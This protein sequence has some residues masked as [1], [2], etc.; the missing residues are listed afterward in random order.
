MCNP[1]SRLGSPSFVRLRRQLGRDGGVVNSRM[2]SVVE[3]FHKMGLFTHEVLVS[4][5][6][7]PWLER[8]VVFTISPWA[9][10]RGSALIGW[11]RVDTLVGHL[12]C[13]AAADGEALSCL[14]RIHAVVRE[15]SRPRLCLVASR[16][17]SST[18]LYQCLRN[19][20]WSGVRCRG[21]PPVRVSS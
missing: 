4:A 10:S 21:G 5:S 2:L 8:R 18:S 9:G 3:A 20:H 11:P 14:T 15:N 7:G 19:W 17:R 6:C 13:C 16:R 12:P 1:L